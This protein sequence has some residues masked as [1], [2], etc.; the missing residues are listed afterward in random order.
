MF[1]NSGPKLDEAAQTKAT[2]ITPLARTIQAL[3]G[4]NGIDLTFD[5]AI[6]YAQATAMLAITSELIVLN[7]HLALMHGAKEGG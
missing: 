3:N 6:Q 2:T 1:K 5:Q 4:L 7:S